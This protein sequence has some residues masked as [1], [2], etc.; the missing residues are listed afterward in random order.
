M[1]NQIKVWIY[2]RVS[3]QRK[4]YLLDF[5]EEILRDFADNQKL[6]VVGVTKEVSS[7]KHLDSF[8]CKAMTNC[9]R[10]KRVNIILCV[11]PKRLCLYDDQFEEFEM[12]CNMND[13][14]VMSM[15]DI[16]FIESIVEAI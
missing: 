11:T 6:K 7:G 1:N 12:F 5:Q 9:I 16:H 14:V 13:V 10:R 15:E 8:E 2:C 3:E 4:K